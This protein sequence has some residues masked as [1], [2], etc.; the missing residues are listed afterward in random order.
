MCHLQWWDL[1]CD[2]HIEGGIE[3]NNGQAE[4]ISTKRKREKDSGYYRKGR[5]ASKP[6]TSD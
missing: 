5:Q 4:E 3:R 6:Q 2:Q 1:N